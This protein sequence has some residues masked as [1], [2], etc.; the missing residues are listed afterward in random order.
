MS[1]INTN[2]LRI[3]ATPRNQD[4]GETIF[5]DTIYKDGPIGRPHSLE[6]ECRRLE[7]AHTAQAA[8]GTR[9]GAEMTHPPQSAETMIKPDIPKIVAVDSHHNV[10]VTDSSWSDLLTIKTNPNGR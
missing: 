3:E 8:S 2:P 4:T 7:W 5:V 1:R 10:Y 9:Q 6:T